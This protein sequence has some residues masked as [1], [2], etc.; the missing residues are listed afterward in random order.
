MQK[1]PGFQNPAVLISLLLQELEIPLI[2][3]YNQD[4]EQQQADEEIHQ[5]VAFTSSIL[6]FRHA[7]CYFTELG[8]PHS[9]VD[10]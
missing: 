7:L 8:N 9:K 5:A 4:D 1:L 2:D 6:Y 3:S 10:Q